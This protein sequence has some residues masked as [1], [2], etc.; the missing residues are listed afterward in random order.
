MR[1]A[2]G[3]LMLFVAGPALAAS[4]PVDNPRSLMGRWFIRHDK[5]IVAIEPCGNA[6][7][8]RVERVLD[9]DFPEYDVNN[10]DASKRDRPVE[11]INVLLQFTPD[12]DDG[13]WRGEIYD[14]KSGHTYRSLMQRKGAKLEVKGCVGPF[15]KTQIWRRAP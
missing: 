11:G 12:R 15:C 5:A 1:P 2:L 14:P 13:V 3:L 6:L 4:A 10:S 7:C 9:K 8:G